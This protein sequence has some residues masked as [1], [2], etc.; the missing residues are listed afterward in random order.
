MTTYT[1]RIGDLVLGPGAPVA[2]QSMTNTCTADIEETA[3]QV[4]ELARVGSELVR[5]TVKDEDD[6]RAVPYIR[7]R[8][9]QAGCKVPLVGDFHYNGHLL[10]SRYPQCLEAL[11]KLRETATY[12]TASFADADACDAWM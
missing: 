8:V 7:D 9:R 11:D 6:A 5:F 12:Y 1:V 2:V 4:L 10:L 3:A